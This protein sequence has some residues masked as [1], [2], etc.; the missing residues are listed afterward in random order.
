MSELW[1]SIIKRIETGM[2]TVRDAAEV[3]S[4]VKERDTLK[5]MVFDLR[6]AVDALREDIAVRDGLP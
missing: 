6:N 1:K 3:R 2:T 5:Q 4:L